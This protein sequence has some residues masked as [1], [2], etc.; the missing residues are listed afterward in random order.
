MFNRNFWPILLSGA[1]LLFAVGSLWA[2]ESYQPLFSKEM[3]K[4]LDPATR[5]RFAELEQEN[6]QRWR[7]RNPE[8]PNADAARRQHR[9]TEAM[10]RR[11]EESR[12]L[13]AAT[14]A[15][16][17]PS[18]KQKKTCAAV[19]SEI[20]YLQTGGKF[21]VQADDGGRRYLSDPEIAARV[22]SQQ[23]RYKRFCRG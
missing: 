17:Q 9:E 11:F 10:L 3:L 23:K 21:Y 14:K 6:Y 19:A 18:P 15:A 5:D 22:K 4:S 2:G 8:Q 7:N 13:K 12:A 1:V 20:E 16:N